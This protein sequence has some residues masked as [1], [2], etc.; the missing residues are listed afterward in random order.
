MK[1]EGVGWRGVTIE[2]AAVG[3]IPQCRR[4]EDEFGSQLS[5]KVT[6]SA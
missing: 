3:L 5:I 2:F 6:P 4:G 1:T